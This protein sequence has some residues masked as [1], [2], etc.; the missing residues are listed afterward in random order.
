MKEILFIIL[1]SA[2]LLEGF[3]YVDTA[4]RR[5]EGLIKSFLTKILISIAF[6][7]SIFV[8]LYLRSNIEEPMSLTHNMGLISLAVGLIMRYWTYYLTKPFFTR[9]IILSEDRPLF[10]SG[11]FRFTRHPYHTGF[12]LIVLGICLFI[13]GHWLTSLTTFLFL[14]SALHY[15]MTLE[16]SL[17]Y[18]KYGDIYLYWCRHRFRLLPFIY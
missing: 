18:K 11:P 13:S 14:G 8:S 15:R 9:S 3:V 7:F 6:L 4:N 17:Y 5:K 2:W 16:E 10:S 1:L 12:F